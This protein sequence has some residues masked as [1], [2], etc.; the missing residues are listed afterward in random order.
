MWVRMWVVRAEERAK[1]LGQKSQEK[2]FSPVWVR[3]WRVRRLG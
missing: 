3:M 1:A 2:G